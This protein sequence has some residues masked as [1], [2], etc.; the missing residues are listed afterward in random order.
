MGSWVHSGGA[1]RTYDLAFMSGDRRSAGRDY[2]AKRILKG[3]Q[4]R[5]G[6]MP[7]RTELN[8]YTLTFLTLL[9]N[10][11]GKGFAIG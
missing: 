10:L 2:A 6:R 1:F 8:S 11:Q 5:P 9:F 7:D 3:L 4:T